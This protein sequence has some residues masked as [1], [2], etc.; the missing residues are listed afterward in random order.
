[1]DSSH[2]LVVLGIDANKVAHAARFNIIDEAAV[3]KA[4]NTRSFKIGVAKTKEAAEAAGKLIEGKIFDSGRGSVPVVT[5]EQYDQLLKLLEIG[6]TAEPVLPKAAASK[7]P[8][9]HTGDLWKAIKVGAL[10]LAKDP[11]PGPERS[12]WPVIIKEVTG[13]AGDALIVQYK[14]Y[15][16]LPPFRVKRNAVAL[17]HK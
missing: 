4:A 17:L 8:P 3:R 9:N 16:K 6:G 10:V 2:F 11:D 7:A 5:R 14:D 1:M 15:P 12:Y 13:K